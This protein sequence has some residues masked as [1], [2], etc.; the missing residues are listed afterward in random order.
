VTEKKVSQID[1][2]ELRR[3]AEERLREN[4][5]T[6]NPPGTEDEPLRLHHEL[7]VHQVE[8]EMQN[9]ELRQTRD[10]LEKALEEYTD[11]YDF[12]PVGYFTLDRKGD[13]RNV[14]LTGAR[15]CIGGVFVRHIN[16]L[17]AMEIGLLPAISERF[18]KTAGNTASPDAKPSSFHPIAERV[19]RRRETVR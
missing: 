19:W 12:A 15:L 1:G 9:A 5:G 7:Q 14:N 6:A 18:M 17:N 3:Q 11:L 4:R 2:A 13:T 16:L 10:D 8:L